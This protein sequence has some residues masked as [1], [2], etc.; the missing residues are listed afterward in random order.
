MIPNGN[1]AYIRV[2]SRLFVYEAC[3]LLYTALL[4]W[5]NR[6]QSTTMNTS[7]SVTQFIESLN[8]WVSLSRYTTHKFTYLGLSS[9]THMQPWRFLVFTLNSHLISPWIPAGLSSGSQPEKREGARKWERDNE[10]ENNI[11]LTNLNNG[12]DPPITQLSAKTGH[13]L[14]GDYSCEF[15]DKLSVR[16]LYSVQ[17]FTKSVQ[18]KKMYVS[19]INDM[20]NMNNMVN[21]MNYNCHGWRQSE[22]ALSVVWL[23][24]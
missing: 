16:H 2:L 8:N 3:K 24:Y 11:F 21:H 4:E 7:S 23:K 17:T 12:Q 20:N 9:H 22:D 18:K 14:K 13:I 5:P 6:V 15:N 19:N 10:G 1:V